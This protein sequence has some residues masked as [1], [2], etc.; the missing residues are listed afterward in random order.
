M[1]TRSPTKI[2]FA[3][4]LGPEHSLRVSPLTSHGFAAMSTD[5]GLP[6]AGDAVTLSGFVAL[7]DRWDW[8]PPHEIHIWVTFLG[9][10]ERPGIRRKIADDPKWAEVTT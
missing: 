1:I 6:R 7:V 8:Y 9:A 3:T 5:L 2:S 4:D 10:A